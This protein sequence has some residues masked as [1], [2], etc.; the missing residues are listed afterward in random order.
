MS[1]DA[2]QRRRQAKT[3]RQHV[4]VTRFAEIFAEV[5]VAAQYLAEHTFRAAQV[6]VAL[7]YGGTG[8]EPLS[9]RSILLHARVVRREIL[10]HQPIA[11]RTGPVEDVM[12][13][14]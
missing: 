4:L 7:L 6:D 14:L 1:E 10:L 5:F 3:V 8:R 13:V 2:G 12:R 11:V 9:S